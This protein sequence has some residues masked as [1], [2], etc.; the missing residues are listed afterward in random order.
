[1]LNGFY[2][3][4]EDK[5]WVAEATEELAGRQLRAEVA[6]ISGCSIRE[7]AER[8]GA[9]AKR[10]L[11]EEVAQQRKAP[12]HSFIHPSLHSLVH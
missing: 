10:S 5:N 9:S 12:I 4:R 6:Q 7:V 11:T 3:L 8:R 2:Q 1:L